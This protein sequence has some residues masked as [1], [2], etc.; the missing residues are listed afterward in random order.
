MDT[1]TF[2]VGTAG[3]VDHGKSTLVK[4]LTG[5]DPDR[6]QEEKDRAL[7]ID[8]GFAWFAL[9][10]GSSASIVDVPGHERFIKNM[11]AGVGGIDAAL[12]IVAADEGP[13]PQTAEHLA[14][15]DLF[16]ISNGIVVVTKRDLVEPDW[17]DLIVEETREAL[18]PTVLAGASI[19]PVSSVTGEG[20]DELV[21]ALDELLA[22]LPDRRSHG[23]PRLAVDRVFT[24]SGFG[25]VV[26]G[27]LL[28]DSLR[29]GQE[30]EL[31]PAGTRTRIRGLQVHGEAV[32]RAPPGERTA[33]N[34]T[35]VDR[36]DVQRGDLLTVPSW[37][38][39]TLLLDARVRLVPNAPRALEQN[40]PVDFFVGAS[41]A[42]AHITILAAESLRPGE[43]GWV[44]LR[45]EVPVVA[46]ER[47]LFIIRQASPSLTIGGG[48]VVNAH[49]RRHRRF[50]AD[51][52][53][54]LETRATGTPLDRLVQL[55]S[56]GPRSVRDASSALEV[57]LDEIREIV[58]EGVTADS[59]RVLGTA[60]D[61]KVDPGRILMH[62]EQFDQLSQ[63]AIELIEH[64][65]RQSPLRAGMPREELRSRLLLAPRVYDAF[66]QNL[67]AAGTVINQGDALSAPEFTVTFTDDQQSR[68]DR[69]V[70]ALGASPNAPPAPSDF[71]LDGELIAAIEGLG[72]VVHLSDNVVFSAEHLD[73][74]RQETLAMIDER[75]SLTLA[76]FRD[77]FGSSR[78]YA[79]AVLE[80]FD[81]RK[82]TRRVGDKRVRGSG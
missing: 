41:E 42:S 53:Q 9:P 70:A 15:L 29:V 13:M 32:E 7:T 36:D 82:V 49:P 66:M 80:H 40:D 77:H 44:Q 73:R 27:T 81:A 61:E 59:L 16:G 55:L 31:L 62:T 6:L 28:G 34:L 38:Q 2:V 1:R 33:V 72:L 22:T 35:G 18:A 58:R 12:L 64:F 46:V 26:T 19:I 30:V 8:L 14:I 74:V 69:Y 20:I 3:H 57:D 76:E 45:F 25:T 4:Y 63:R 65:H 60:D 48:V 51:V 67:T 47:D 17:L 50:R 39:P 75:G 11:L 37:V 21:A 79:Q 23:R 54:E 56:E 5:T 43:E 68:I 52:V 71:G 10:S 24:V 78:K